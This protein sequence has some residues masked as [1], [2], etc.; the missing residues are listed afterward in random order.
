M[1]RHCVPWYSGVVRG[2]ALRGHLD[3]LILATLSTG[4]MHGYALIE[5]LRLRSH[6]EFDLPEGTVYPI[7]HRLQ[8]E[9]A[10][11]SRWSDA[12]GRKRRVYWLTER[13]VSALS[14]ERASWSK[15]A[16]AVTSTV[17]GPP[18]PITP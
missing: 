18:W 13:G 8:S 12:S 11:A 17:Q 10:L 7:L 1:S 2:D 5:Q 9:G 6:G 4:E 14:R 15:F 3:L 16:A